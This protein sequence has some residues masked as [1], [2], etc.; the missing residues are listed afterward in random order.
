[1]GW[2][3]IRGLDG[4]TRDCYVG[5]VRDWKGRADVDNLLPP[6]ATRC[7]RVCGAAL[8]RSRGPA[9]SRGRPADQHAGHGALVP[10]I[11]GH[12]G[13]PVNAETPFKPRQ[14]GSGWRLAVL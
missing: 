2:I 10:R 1:V 9:R 13:D 4:V 3:R 12:L 7:A 5:P 6:G 8:G 11:P 14:A